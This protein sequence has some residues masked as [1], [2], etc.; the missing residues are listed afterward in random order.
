VQ[1]YARTPAPGFL[2]LPGRFDGAWFL[3]VTYI[4]RIS[5]E[6]SAGDLSVDELRYYA[7]QL[8]LPGI[9]PVGQRKLKAARVLVVGAGGLGCPALQGL[10]GAGVGRLTVIDGDRVELSNRSRQWLHGRLDEGRNK[11]E[12]AAEALRETNP[13]IEVHA[14]PKHL[15]GDSVERLVSTHD[16]VVDATDDLEVRYLLDD[17]CARTDRPWVFAGLYRDR[18]Q[19]TCLWSRCGARF[20]DFFPN[21]GKVPSCAEAGML[22]ATASVVG[23]LQ[24]LEAIKWVTACARPKLGVLVSLDMDGVALGEFRLP[25][26]VIPPRIADPEPEGEGVTPVSLAQAR[27]IHEPILLID[28]RPVSAYAIDGWTEAL[29]CPAEYILE[30]GLPAAAHGSRKVVFICEKGILS[31]LLANAMRRHIDASVTHLE[32]GLDAWRTWER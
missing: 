2:Q 32:G 16:L 4:A 1:P 25:D 8:L 15:S 22:G 5:E 11:A 13:Y 14:I 19:V 12:S 9:G 10:A 23:H 21:S 30:T 17:A 20:R 3:D 7:R 24:A 6:Y 31:A 29:S 28:I 26:V 27:S 18:A